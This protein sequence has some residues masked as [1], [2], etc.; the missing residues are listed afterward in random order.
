[1]T[2]EEFAKIAAS[3][4]GGG[5]GV[6]LLSWWRF[7]GKDRADA[8]QIVA[9]AAAA[10]VEPLERRIVVLQDEVTKLRATNM[11]LEAEI[12]HLRTTVEELKKENSRLMG[13]EGSD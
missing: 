9:Q 12:H 13:G 10:L 8:A 3:V 7:R 4:I 1:M 11:R 5:A 6:G 2:S